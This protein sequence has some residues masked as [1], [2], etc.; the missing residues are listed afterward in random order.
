MHTFVTATEARNGSRNNI[1]IHTEVR[2][3]ESAIL[4]AISTGAYMVT[5]STS[6]MTSG[7]NAAYYCRAWRNLEDLPTLEDQ[8]TQVAKHFKDLGYNVVQK[9]NTNTLT[10]FNWEIYW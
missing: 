10:T 5:I 4:T 3:I 7:S 1:A 6:A 9:L 2:F 8:M